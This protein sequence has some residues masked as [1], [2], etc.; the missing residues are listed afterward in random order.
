MKTGKLQVLVVDDEKSI[1]LTLKEFLEDEG[2]L[3]TTATGFAEAKQSLAAW[4][5]EVAVID[6]ILSNGYGGLD[7]I[8]HINEVKPL[9]QTILITA[10]P[11]I[12][13]AQVCLKYGAC[14][15]LVKPVARGDICRAV[16]DAS[17]TS[18]EN[19]QREQVQSFVQ[20]H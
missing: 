5:F 2:F 20:Q 7:L 12:E 4:D 16:R 13:S 17:Q 6:R 18:I 3:V 8:K 19:K 14:D 11:T 1:R 9:C 10:Y 15:C